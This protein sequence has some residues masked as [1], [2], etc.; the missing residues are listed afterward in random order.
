MEG[1]TKEEK[2]E[3]Q[4]WLRNDR[5]NECR[6]FKQMAHFLL[7]HA[8]ARGLMGNG[9]IATETVWS[10]DEDVAPQILIILL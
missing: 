10:R 1:K 7:C 5:Q 3:E 8:A 6:W 2:K 9:W 4:A